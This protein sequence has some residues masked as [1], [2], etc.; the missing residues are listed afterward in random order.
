MEQLYRATIQFKTRF[1]TKLD[2]LRIKA[3]KSLAFGRSQLPNSPPQQLLRVVAAT[4]ATAALSSF[5]E[6]EEGEERCHLVLYQLSRCAGARRKIPTEAEEEEPAKQMSGTRMKGEQWPV[7]LHRHGLTAQAWPR[8]R[9]G[10]L[11]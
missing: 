11:G 6:E 8:S 4:W 2:L 3:L 5:G 10:R 7:D 1:F 9:D